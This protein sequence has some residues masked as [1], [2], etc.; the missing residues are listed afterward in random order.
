M[1]I[2]LRSNTTEQIKGKKRD[3]LQL[4]KLG[5]L[6]TMRCLLSWQA[7]QII[8]EEERK[9]SSICYWIQDPKQLSPLFHA[10]KSPISSMKGYSVIQR[11]SNQINR[12]KFDR[13]SRNI[14]KVVWTMMA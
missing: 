9:G 5:G 3:E 10:L 12:Q 14:M 11:T 8:L 13:E 4:L 1:G 2:R 7:L 6:V